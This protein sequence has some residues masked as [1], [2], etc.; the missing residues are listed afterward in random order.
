M[1]K[2][3]I[4]IVFL[5]FIGCTNENGALE[6]LE[7]EGCTNIQITGYRVFGCSQDD[8]FHT[9]FECKRNGKTVTGVVCQGVLKGKTIR[10]D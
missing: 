8:T 9:G 10:Y 6:L 2:I 4:A 7:A 3:F 5:M 1:K